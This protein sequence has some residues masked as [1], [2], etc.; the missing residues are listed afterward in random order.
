M[1]PSPEPGDPRCS[2]HCTWGQAAGLI[3]SPELQ[4]LDLP[5]FRLWPHGPLGGAAAASWSWCF[6]GRGQLLPQWW[7]GCRCRCRPWSCGS[8]G[9]VPCSE[10][11]PPLN[12]G[13]QSSE[14]SL[15][16]V[17]ARERLGQ[18]SLAGLGHWK[19]SL[20]AGPKGPGVRSEG[21]EAPPG[22]PSE[23]VGDVTM[24][25]LQG[26]RSCFHHCLCR[27]PGLGEC[28]CQPGQEGA[29]GG[30]GSSPVARAI[31]GTPR[32]LRVQGQ[33]PRVLGCCG[34]SPM[35]PLE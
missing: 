2:R 15:V 35:C 26:T 30:S 21:T 12:C 16:C 3:F 32:T 13:P 22:Q 18:Q 19:A 29:G 24:P 5:L 27:Q 8:A 11:S 28:C 20:W 10:A 7:A 25:C 9:P 4:E 33:S 1:H 14:Q 34:T 17:G 31:R 23:T 6:P